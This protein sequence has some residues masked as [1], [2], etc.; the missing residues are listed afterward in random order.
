MSRKSRKE[1]R[2]L[3]QERQPYYMEEPMFYGQVPGLIPVAAPSQQAIQLAPI[4][5]P[6]ALVPYGTQQK[7]QQPVQSIEDDDYDY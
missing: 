7:Q 2:L 1:E 5:Q 6:I 3:E 4:I